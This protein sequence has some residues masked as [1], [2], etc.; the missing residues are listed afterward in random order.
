MVDLLRISSAL[1]A[2]ITKSWHIPETPLRSLS[3]RKKVLLKMFDGM[4]EPR[5]VRILNPIGEF[6]KL[7]SDPVR[8][9]AP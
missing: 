5:T 6:I 4:T 8:L 1:I 3:I 7:M 9:G 2:M